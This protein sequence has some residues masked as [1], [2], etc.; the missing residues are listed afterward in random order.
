M[1][2]DLSRPPR[3]SPGKEVEVRLVSVSP[4]QVIASRHVGPEGG[5]FKAFGRLLEWAGKKGIAAELRGI[6]G[7]P[8]D[9]AR[10]VPEEE[11][12]FDCCF[13][14]GSSVKSDRAQRKIFLG[15][16]TYAVTRHVGL[17]EGLG[18]TGDS[19]YGFCLNSAGYE[20]RD[21]PSYNHYLADPD[22]LPPEEWETDIYVPIVGEIACS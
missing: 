12:R 17:Y 1:I 8:I 3:Q 18:A 22:T 16:G 19:L 20:I 14:F 10:C 7:I 6:Y 9:D 2:R 5:L 11:C 4:F 21:Q 13:D 15:G